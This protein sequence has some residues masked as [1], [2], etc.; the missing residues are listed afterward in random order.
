MDG[1]AVIRLDVTNAVANDTE[2]AAE[3]IETE[4]C[5]SSFAFA[6]GEPDIWLCWHA[7]H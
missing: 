5:Q 1:H 2:A 4:I 3:E 6:A 7:S